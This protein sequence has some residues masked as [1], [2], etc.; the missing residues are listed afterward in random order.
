MR[1]MCSESREY[2]V[3]YDFV[4]LQIILNFKFNT[5]NEEYKYIGQD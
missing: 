5:N 3:F 4:N 2:T 1:H